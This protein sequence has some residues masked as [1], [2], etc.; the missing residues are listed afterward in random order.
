MFDDG[1]GTVV[2]RITMQSLSPGVLIDSLV[3]DAFVSVM[4]QEERGKL[5]LEREERRKLQQE[6]RRYY[7]PLAATAS[8]F[9]KIHLLFVKIHLF[10]VSLVITQV[11]LVISQ[12][13]L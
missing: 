8:Y 7:F 11:S 4:N 3:I 1:N 5:Q 13:I 10:Q 9:V 2:P 12:V 6:R